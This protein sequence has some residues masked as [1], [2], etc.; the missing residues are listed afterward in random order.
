MV[1]FACDAC[2]DTG[3]VRAGA[4]GSDTG[5]KADVVRCGCQREADQRRVWERSQRMSN[6]S[7]E[8]RRLAFD[9]FDA[10][11]SVSI[12]QAYTVMLRFTEQVTGWVV[13]N[14]ASGLGKTHLLAAAANALLA[15]G[16]APVYV[17]AV[18]FLDY[19]KAA[20]R[21]RQN[22][23]ESGRD[24]DDGFETMERRMEQARTCE[25]LLLDDLAAERETEWSVERFYAL[26][27]YRYRNAL[28][29]VLASNL[30]PDDFPARVASRLQDRRLC[31][32][33]EMT[34]DDYRLRA[35]RRRGA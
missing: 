8:M 29:T 24:A 6:L 5:W 19:L 4:F 16:H 2:H 27:E 22:G 7:P 12:Q 21:S 17:V 32:V 13:L 31:R 33:V 34:G 11:R 14:G 15:A 25:V 28:P 30:H 26:L 3:W 1:R 18:D 35:E 20:M 10:G 9:G 23:E